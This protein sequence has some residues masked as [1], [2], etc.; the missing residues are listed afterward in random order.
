M[1][2][3]ASSV[4]KEACV[5]VRRRSRVTA[6]ENNGDSEADV[7]KSRQ[8]EISVQRASGRGTQIFCR[9]GGEAAEGL[10]TGVM[11]T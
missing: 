3:A 1:I 10:R 9:E 2:N 6:I 11:P 8:F 7:R 5:F 4:P